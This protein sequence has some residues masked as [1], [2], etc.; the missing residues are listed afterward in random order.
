MLL[1]EEGVVLEDT[2]EG[3]RWKRSRN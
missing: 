3:V 2:P 1:Q